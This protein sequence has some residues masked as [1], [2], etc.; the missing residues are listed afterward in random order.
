MVNEQDGSRTLHFI[1]NASGLISHTPA[2]P[3]P[4][5]PWEGVIMGDLLGIWFHP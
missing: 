3:N 2:Y 1:I 4:F 5:E